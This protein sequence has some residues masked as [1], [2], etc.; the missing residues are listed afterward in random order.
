M[1]AEDSVM[2]VLE[3]GYHVVRIDV[4]RR[5]RNL[6]IVAQ[7]GNPIA[8]GIPAIVILDG[9]G[10]ALVA[11]NQ[12][13]LATARSMDSQQVLVVLRRWLPGRADETK[14]E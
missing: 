3:S 4:G 8:G 10:G 1:F 14:A 13:E 5:D 12:G 9:A 2:A 6:D 11:T 7:Y